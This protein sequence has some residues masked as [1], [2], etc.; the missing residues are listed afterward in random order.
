MLVL[1]QSAF[2]M[3]WP[4]LLLLAVFM[5]YLRVGIRDPALQRQALSKGAAAVLALV[6]L[7]I[8]IANIRL[9]F[10][11]DSRLLPLSLALITVGSFLM[12]LYFVRVSA[13]FKIGAFMFLVAAALAGFGNWL[14][15]VE[16]G[17]LPPPDPQIDPSTFTT[18]ELA[19]EGE[20]IIFGGIGLSRVQGAAGKGQCPL[21]HGFN[22]G[23]LSERAP[24]LFGVIARAKQRLEDPR[25]HKGKPLDRDTV[26]KEA[27]AGAGTAETVQEYL[28]ESHVC[29]SCYVVSGFGQKGTNDR[30][31]PMARVNKPPISLT[32]SEL[33]MVDTW[34]YV[35]E[36]IEP[37]SY[38]EI[39]KAYEKFIPEADRMAMDQDNGSTQK[40]AP[41][42]SGKDSVDQIFSQAKCVLCHTIPG[43]SG[44]T[45]VIGPKLVEGTNAPLRLKD[46]A[47]QGQAKTVRDYVMESVISPGTY[48]V[49]PFQDNVMPRD[50]GERLSAGALTKIV[51]YLSK[52][53]EGKTPSL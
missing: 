39:V 18:Q 43:I 38:A 42:V 29:P 28:A 45:G 23:Y 7:L 19:D 32:I 53:E 46:P 33:A 31:S 34:L 6:L 15:Q 5:L 36:G 24:N 44:A 52:L 16:G 37:P 25:Y 14:P 30:E 26:Q 8:A 20:K 49:I 21:C 48:V 51:D 2:A 13:L 9:N 4:L 10:F 27:I 47:Y 41:I 40:I 11:G 17:F 1:L 12:S 22:Q 3:G 35:R 50:F